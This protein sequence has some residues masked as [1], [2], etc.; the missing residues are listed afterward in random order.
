MSKKNVHLHL[1][2]DMYKNIYSNIIYNNQ[3]VINPNAHQ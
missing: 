2:K 1:V 3:N